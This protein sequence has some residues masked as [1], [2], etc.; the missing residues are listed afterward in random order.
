L[1][2]L[3]SIMIII[4][5]ESLSILVDLVSPFSGGTNDRLVA[6][7]LLLL[8][9]SMLIRFLQTQFLFGI[10]DGLL[11]QPCFGAEAPDLVFQFSALCL[12]AFLCRCGPLDLCPI[13]LEL[14]L[15][16]YLQYV[17]LGFHP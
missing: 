5:N 11:S 15:C 8:L 1:V 3:Y 16:S 10:P 2:S 12:D 9:P 13:V 6:E 17:S 14:E 7:V 4:Q